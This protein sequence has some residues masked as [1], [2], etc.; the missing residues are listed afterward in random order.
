MRSVPHP[1]QAGL[2]VMEDIR[3]G[4]VFIRRRTWLWGTLVSAAFAYLLFL[5]PTE[6]LLPYVVKNGLHGSAGT[7]GTVFAAGGIG[8]IGAARAHGPARAAAPP[9]H[10]HLH[11]LDGRD[12][13]GR[14]LRAGHRD[15]AAGGRLPRV[16]RARDGRD[17]RVGDAQAAARARVDAGAGVEPRLADLDRPPAA[18]VRADG[19]AHCRARRAADPGRRRRRRGRDHPRPRSSCPACGTSS[20]RRPRPTSPEPVDV[21]VAR[22]TLHDDERGAAGAGSVAGS[23]RDDP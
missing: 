6:V 2:S 17:D 3:T 13:C 14:G 7:L 12:A 19:T 4:L 15:L 23:R 16:Q 22:I 5:G 20:G 8:S 9:G 18:L 1:V 11:R 10:V 21:V